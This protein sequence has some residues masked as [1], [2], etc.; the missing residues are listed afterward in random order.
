MRPRKGNRSVKQQRI[1][2]SRGELIEMRR[3]LDL[4][5]QEDGYANVNMDTKSVKA[6]ASAYEKVTGLLRRKATA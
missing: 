1:V 3:A 6:K 5:Q 2:F 4:I